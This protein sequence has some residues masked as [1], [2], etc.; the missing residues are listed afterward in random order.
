MHELHVNVSHSVWGQTEEADVD[1][2]V[3]TLVQLHS[4]GMILTLHPQFILL[5][6]EGLH[7]GNVYIQVQF[8]SIARGVLDLHSLRHVASLT[9][10]VEHSTADPS[11][12]KPFMSHGS[13]EGEII[14]SYCY[15]EKG[16]GWFCNSPSESSALKR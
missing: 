16:L 1:P 10:S 9:E 13:L 12:A 5:M 15:V 14:A 8:I 11:A 7:A 4:P 3:Y 6:D 2:G